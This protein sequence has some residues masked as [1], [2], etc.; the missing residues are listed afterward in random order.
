MT[1]GGILSEEDWEMGWKGP[2]GQAVCW[3]VGKGV[4]GAS[5]ITPQRNRAGDSDDS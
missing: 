1:R 2:S 3:P 4:Y 5:V